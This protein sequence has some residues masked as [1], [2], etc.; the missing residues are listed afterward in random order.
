MLLVLVVSGGLLA[1]LFRAPA[2]RQALMVS[3][4]VALVVQLF[5]F[6]IARAVGPAKAF[7]GFTIGTMLR[8]VTLVVY[9][10][11]VVRLAELPPVAALIGLATFFF[12]STILE[13]RLL[14]T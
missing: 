9:G 14:K 7:T 2:E 5:A 8:L 3:A 12:L 13:T 1:L 6:A 11:A 4:G 10:V